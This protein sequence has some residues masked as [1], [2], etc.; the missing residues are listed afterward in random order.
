MI[1]L[2]SGERL[3]TI[4]RHDC[5]N[6]S[7]SQGRKTIFLNFLSRLCSWFQQTCL[8]VI[9]VFYGVRQKTTNLKEFIAWEKIG[10]NFTV[11]ENKVFWKLMAKGNFCD[12]NIKLHN[13]PF[14][15]KT[16]NDPAHCGWKRSKTMKKK[17]IYFQLTAGKP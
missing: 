9:S 14:Y 4:Y 3:R 17:P 12:P 11:L 8:E 16:T 2:W 15:A 1:Y 5:Q 7:I 6:Q 10:Y 13:R